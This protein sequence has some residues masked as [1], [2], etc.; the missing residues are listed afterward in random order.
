[1]TLSWVVKPK[2]LDSKDDIAT[3]MTIRFIVNRKIV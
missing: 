3:A 1:M 2:A